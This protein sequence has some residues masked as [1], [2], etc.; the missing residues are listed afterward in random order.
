MKEKEVAGE[1]EEEKEG[2][3]ILWHPHGKTDRYN[4]VWK[5]RTALASTPR[6]LHPLGAEGLVQY[7]YF[8]E[9][10]RHMHI[11][12]HI[13]IKM[14]IR[15][16]IH[17]WIKAVTNIYINKNNKPLYIHGVKLKPNIL[18]SGYIIEI[19]MSMWKSWVCFKFLKS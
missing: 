19:N 3:K 5:Q 13:D 12:I 15:I 1:N 16:I 10:H 18:R 6:R 17:I 4:T 8:C 7:R 9:V 2:K 14:N 11:H